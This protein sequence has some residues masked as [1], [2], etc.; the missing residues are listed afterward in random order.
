MQGMVVGSKVG[1]WDRG[2]DVHDEAGPSST[3]AVVPEGVPE[4]TAVE[5]DAGEG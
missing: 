4:G 1:C 3:A 2:L 5:V